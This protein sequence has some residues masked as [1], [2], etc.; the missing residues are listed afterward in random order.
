MESNV[1]LV[2]EYDPATVET[3]VRFPDVAL[4]FSFLVYMYSRMLR[5]RERA[6][7]NYFDLFLFGS[8]FRECCAH[9]FCAG[10]EVSASGPVTQA[11]KVS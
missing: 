9:Q 1:G 3:R 7:H 11:A 8:F 5:T 10:L 6:Y 4:T 2:V